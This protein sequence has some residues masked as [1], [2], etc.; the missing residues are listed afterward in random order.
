MCG[1][2][3]KGKVIL[4]GIVGFTAKRIFYPSKIS[5]PV[6]RLSR[7]TPVHHLLCKLDELLVFC[8]GHPILPVSSSIPTY[9]D[10]SVII[11]KILSVRSIAALVELAIGGKRPDK[12]YPVSEVRIDN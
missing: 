2:I 10:I 12:R 7:L 4:G 11:F 5:S 9:W 8:Q 6:F 1:K 3:D